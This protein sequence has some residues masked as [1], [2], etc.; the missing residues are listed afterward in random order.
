MAID[1]D[2]FLNIIDQM[3]ITIPQEIKRAR[4]VQ[5]ERDKYVAQA[6]E[7]AR[8]IIAQAREEA[9]RQ[10]EE[11][12]LRKEAEAEAQKIITRAQYEALRI[13]SGADEFAEAKLQELGEQVA[14]LQAVIENGLGALKSRRVQ[15]VREELAEDESEQK[16]KAPRLAPGAKPPI[17][18]Q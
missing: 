5:Q 15:E 14:K 8:N 11:H 6:H 18:I 17:R 3:R 10:L 4:E 9:V 16:D 7:E 1:E 2:M 13:R 12:R